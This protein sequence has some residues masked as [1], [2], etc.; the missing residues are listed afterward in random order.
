MIDVTVVEMIRNDDAIVGIG[1]IACYKRKCLFG[2]V[3]N[4][5]HGETRLIE[6]SGENEHWDVDF[7]NKV[8][9]M[10]DD[11]KAWILIV[12]IFSFNIKVVTVLKLGC[13]KSST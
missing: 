9:L 11:E 13:E 12:M 5:F 4:G 10:E 6:L 1:D 8:V 7:V 3:M 2:L